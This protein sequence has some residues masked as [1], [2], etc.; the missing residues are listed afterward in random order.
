MRMKRLELILQQP[1]GVVCKRLLILFV[2]L[3]VQCLVWSTRGLC[4]GRS[5]GLHGCVQLLGAAVAR[6][7]GLDAQSQSRDPHL[8]LPLGALVWRWQLSVPCGA[9]PS[10]ASGKAGSELCIPHWEAPSSHWGRLWT[11]LL[12]IFTIPC[13]WLLCLPWGWD[14]PPV[15][16]SKGWCVSGARKVLQNH[17]QA[18]SSC[19]SQS[20]VVRDKNLCVGPQT[21]HL[22]RQH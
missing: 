19:I 2:L 8:Q 12:W 3:F 1:Y 6:C 16:Q 4:L 13:T 9:V 7:A 18:G 11:A 10:P 15:S 14:Q 17:E 22:S 20:D 5:L 21:E